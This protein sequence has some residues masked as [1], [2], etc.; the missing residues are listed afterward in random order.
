MFK[1]NAK[2][3]VVG[4]LLQHK[5]P[6]YS[7]PLKQHDGHFSARALRV[8][9][10]KTTLKYDPLKKLACLPPRELSLAPPASL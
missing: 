1:G 8:A 9:Q 7:P 6:T 10:I 3:Y 2:T 5:M 4:F